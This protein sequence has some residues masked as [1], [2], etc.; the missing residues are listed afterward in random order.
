M[1][2][3]DSHDDF[4]VEPVRGLPG[5]PPE[6][7][8]VLW[9]GSP[10]WRM[11]ARHA[12][13]LRIVLLYFGLLAVWRGGAVGTEQGLG[14][15]L[16]AV[17][18]YVLLGACLAAVL[19]VLARTMAKAT[20]YTITTE[21]VAMRIGVALTVTLNLPL[22]WIASADLRLHPGGTGDIFLRLGGT[23]RLS[24]LVLWPHMRPWRVVRAEPAL[25]CIP[26]AQRVAGLL[27]AAASARVA[28]LPTEGN[29]HGY[30]PLA[31]E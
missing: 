29:A 7:E 23:T 14:A 5:R 1:A 19:A 10:D 27:G 11:L 3:Q 24:A 4:A 26:D 15:G 21:R 18:F 2:G 20:V 12:L 22:R 13:G 16:W 30:H 17:A 31:A 25:R 28:T 8:R 6:G 9:Q